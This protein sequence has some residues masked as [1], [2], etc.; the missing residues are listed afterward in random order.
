MAGYTR[1]RIRPT[2]C[3]SPRRRPEA[4]GKSRPASRQPEAGGSNRPP[5]DEQQRK[6]TAPPAGVRSSFPRL[7]VQ[8]SPRKTG[9]LDKREAGTSEASDDASAP[10]FD[11]LA[12]P[13]LLKAVVR[14]LKM[15]GGERL[16]GMLV[17]LPA[18]PGCTAS[19]LRP[20]SRFNG[21]PGEQSPGAPTEAHGGGPSLDNYHASSS[22]PFFPSAN[23]ARTATHEQG[24]RRLA[25]ER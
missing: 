15:S 6:K 14:Y 23:P 18:T 19:A 9:G 4:S 10:S 24:L 22:E 11:L 25:Q 5:L 12:Q 17:A 3:C 20:R 2:T 1:S 7:N 13:G 16:D 8:A 21:S